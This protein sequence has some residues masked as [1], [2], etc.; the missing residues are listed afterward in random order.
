MAYCVS[1]DELYLYFKS[2]VSCFSRPLVN[3]CSFLFF[4][5]ALSHEEY[6][7]QSTKLSKALPSCM[8]RQKHDVVHIIS[9]Y[10][11]SL[12]S[13]DT[14]VQPGRAYRAHCHTRSY[15][16]T[17]SRSTNHGL[18]FFVSS[19]FTHGWL[20]RDASNPPTILGQRK[21]ETNKNAVMIRRSVVVPPWV[22][23]RGLPRE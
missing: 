9:R 3:R 13:L 19:F 22:C 2:C 6:S 23:S 1:T 5:W 20:G 11:H 14:Q 8:L 12:S 10:V 17:Y 7:Y 15:N 21:R 4:L 18:N 16:S